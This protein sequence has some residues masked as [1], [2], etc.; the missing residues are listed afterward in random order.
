MSDA[1]AARH[2]D[3]SLPVRRGFRTRRPKWMVG[4]TAG[5]FLFVYLPVVV[6]VLY[7]FNGID[8]IF[9]FHGTSLQWYRELFANDSMWQSIRTSIGIAAVTSIVATTIGALLALA[10]LR[11][12]GLARS[13]PAVLVT[14]ILV[15]PETVLAV[16]LLLLFTNRSVPLSTTTIILGHVTFSISFAT[17][18]IRTRLMSLPPD[19]EDAALDL[20]ATRAGAVR[21]IVLP[22]LT[23]ALLGS[24]VLVF[25]LSFDDFVTS[26]FV[27]GVGETTLPVRIYS[28]VRFG[29]TPEV[30]AVG[31]LMLCSSLVLA[32]VT[33]GLSSWRARRKFADSPVSEVDRP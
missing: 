32:A 14:L 1:S 20:G 17:I 31:T 19:L 9:S 21:L 29:V 5:V 3:E 15:T 7:S 8:S 18:V 26:V 28:S 12:T 22:H 23:P 27:S 13:I 30:N 16:S 10:L 2:A 11:A 25:L 6:V 24:F 4:V 33:Y